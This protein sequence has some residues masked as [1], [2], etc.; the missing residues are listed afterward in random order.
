MSQPDE[1]P[2]PPQN[3]L[4]SQLRELG[5]QI[6]AA[7]RN[8]MQSDKARQVQQDVAAGMK[9]IGVQL[10]SA[11]KSMQENPKFQEFVERGEQA[12]NQAQQSKIAQDFQESLARGIAQLNDQLAAFITRT[13]EDTAASG[14]TS[15]PSGPATGETTRLDPDEK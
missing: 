8:A 4:A 12:V 5:Q 15:P 7:V 2:N 9:E 14:D 13:R 6:E 10:Q 3:D 11:V 1:Q